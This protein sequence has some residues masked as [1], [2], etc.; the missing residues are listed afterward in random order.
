MPTARLT[1]KGRITIP[2]SVRESLRLR[3]GDVVT[4]EVEGEAAV[5]RP[6]TK[7]VEE[8]FGKLRRP[9]RRRRTVAEMEAGV[10]ARLRAAKS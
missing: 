9:G 3:T 7:S 8:V 6:V 2:K 1:S 4:F 5:M 10:A